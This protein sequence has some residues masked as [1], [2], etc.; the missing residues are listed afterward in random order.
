MS[1]ADFV[2]YLGSAAALAAVSS[3]L[4]Q[5]LRKVR[6]AVDENIAFVLSILFAAVIAIGAKMAIPYLG[7]L[8]PEIENF[9]PVIVWAIQQVWWRIFHTANFSIYRKANKGPCCA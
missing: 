4:L 8:P 1:F 9:W 7:E 3:I 5:L 6:P 2:K